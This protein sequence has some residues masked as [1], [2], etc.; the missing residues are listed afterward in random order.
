[1]SDLKKKVEELYERFIELVTMKDR[2][3][4]D[5]PEMR[6]MSEIRPPTKETKNYS[7]F[8][9]QGGCQPN[10]IHEQEKRGGEELRKYSTL[11]VDGCST[12]EEIKIFTDLGFEIHDVFP[13]D[14]LFR[15]ASFPSGWTKCACPTNPDYWTDIVDETGTVRFHMFYKAAS[16]DRIANI[17]VA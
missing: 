16:Y 13:N 5:E 6:T 14:E 1:M 3:V 15:G 12:P 9:D 7:I 4:D 11:P 8:G 17:V 10:K 2:L